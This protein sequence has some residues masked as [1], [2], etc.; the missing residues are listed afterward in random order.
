M[1]AQYIT[2]SNYLLC[3][4]QPIACHLMKM[5]PCLITSGHKSVTS[6]ELSSL[7]LSS[8]FEKKPQNKD[9]TAS[10][11]Q[12][13]MKLLIPSLYQLWLIHKIGHT[14]TLVIN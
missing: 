10:F 1:L 11:A 4:L 14:L 7:S 8:R 5:D 2:L 6:S 9:D 12:Y 3:F 13:K